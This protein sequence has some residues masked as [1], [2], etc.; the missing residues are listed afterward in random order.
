MIVVNMHLL[1]NNV[2]LSN[3]LLTERQLKKVSFFLYTVATFVSVPTQVAATSA[4]H[5]L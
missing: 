5:T 3:K 2:V 1:C 4:F